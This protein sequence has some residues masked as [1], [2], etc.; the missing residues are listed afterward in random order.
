MRTAVVSMRR[1]VR[2]V[3]RA[4]SYEFEDAVAALSGADIIAPAPAF[5]GSARGMWRL[6]PPAFRRAAADLQMQR[7]RFA[8][9]PVTQNYDLAFVLC[10]GVAD[11]RFLEVLRGWRRRFGCVVLWIED[12]WPSRIR[13]FA[14]S[15]SVHRQAD[16]VVVGVHA[17]LPVARELMGPRCV[18]LPPGVD[19]LAFAPRH[20]DD[21][22]PVDIAW[23]GRRMPGA[24][25][26]LASLAD[27]AG[28]WYHYDTLRAPEYSDHAEHRR[29]LAT[30]VQRTRF[31]IAHRARVDMPEV[32]EGL[33]DIGFR[34]FE[35]AAAGAVMVGEQPR[36]PSFRQN[37][38]WPDAVIDVPA[39]GPEI[40]DVIS[41]LERQPERVRAIRRRNV[42]E[43]LRRHD[44]V[45]RWMDVCRIAGF[46][47][48][49]ACRERVERLEARA[50]EFEAM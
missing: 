32:T 13:R 11:A 15:L 7:R 50:A 3:S 12:I 1:L 20:I 39:E 19:A 16:H 4:C 40:A 10:H 24:H 21:P 23:I 33:H 2:L 5:D 25:G 29:A 37:F 48:S 47:P 41:A 9:E 35:G 28:L 49:P 36:S 34:H 44:W 27:R 31:F 38:D 46:D 22:R 45:Y 43:S 18:Y 8:P 26:A 30:L 14:R 42:I 6:V 17:A